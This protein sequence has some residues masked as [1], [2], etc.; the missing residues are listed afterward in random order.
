MPPYVVRVSTCALNQWALDFDGNLSR[1]ISSC[2][3]AR[4]SGARFRTGPELELTGYGCEDHF[5]ESDTTH[6]A[7]ESLAQLLTGGHTAGLLVDVG[8]PVIHGGVRYNARAFCLDGRVVLLRPKTALADDGNYREGRWFTPWITSRGL[9]TCTLP[10]AFT[11]ATGQ[12]TAP[13][14]IATLTLRDATLAAESCE[15]LFTPN[16]PHVALALAGVDIIANGS[17]SHHQLRKLHT[18]VDLVRGATAKGGGAYLYANQRGCDGGRVYYD[19]CAMAFVDG[20]CLAQGAQFGLLDVEVLTV[21]IDLDAVRARRAARPSAGRQAAAAPLLPTV[22]IDFALGAEDAA[23]TARPSRECNVVYSQPEEEIAR[24][25]A[26]WLW[27]FLRR[28]R[29]S[30]YFL[31]LS[32]GA[33]SAATA[34]IV[35]VMCHMVFEAVAAPAENEDSVGGVAVLA[36]LRRIVGDFTCMWTPASPSDIASRIFHTAYMGTT[37]SSAA[38]RSRAAMLAQQLGAHHVAADIDAAVG[39]LLWV[40]AAFVSHGRLPR[41]SSRG[42]TPTEDLA[43]QNLQA[44]LR[45]VLAYLLAQLLPWLRGSGSGGFLLVLGSANVDEALRGYLTKYDCSSA[46]VNPIGGIS[47]ADLRRFLLHAASRYELPA[48]LDIVLAPPTAELRPMVMTTAAGGSAATFATFGV[49]AELRALNFQLPDDA[50]SAVASL[51]A[52]SPP[53]SSTPSSPSSLPQEHSQTDEEDMGMSYAELSIFGR[54]RKIGLC[55]PLS[56]YRALVNGVGLDETSIDA[57]AALPR[58]DVAIKV[59]RFFKFYAINRH[60]MT[61]LTPAYHAENY[62]PDDNR[63]DLRPFLYNTDW[64]RQFKAI[65]EA[66]LHG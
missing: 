44:R 50:S 11:A 48:L 9:E 59:K 45:M 58:A 34:A 26:C 40:F 18:R 30:G 15:E 43:L 60:K 10:L 12:S 14:G 24:G 17:G 8:L 4:T 47:K 39:A 63:F 16:S 35:G 25:P 20:A 21:N 46:D 62:S 3:S 52:L 37:N 57:W 29:A 64:E 22:T 66:V 51:S 23:T 49:A 36:D 1:V 33:D 65:D 55:G 32:G 31:P 56:M 28:S 5:F 19:G 61:T 7:W 27:D 54:L 38:T 41:F 6:H 13:I 42:G 2:V 53:E